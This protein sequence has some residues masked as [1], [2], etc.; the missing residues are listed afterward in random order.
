MIP[1][2]KSAYTCLSGHSYLNAYCDILVGV[3]TKVSDAECFQGEKTQDWDLTQCDSGVTF[4]RESIS[5]QC[6]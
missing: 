3:G 6:S 5:S 4:S 1:T 2:G